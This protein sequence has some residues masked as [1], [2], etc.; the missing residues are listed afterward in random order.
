MIRGFFDPSQ[1]PHLYLNMAV[2]VDGLVPTDAWPLIPF[3]VDTGAS[4][5]VVH[6]KD[7]VRRLGLSVA[8]LT[9]RS[10][11]AKVVGN[12]GVGGAAVS[13]EVPA[14]YAFQSEDGSWRIVEGNLRIAELADNQHLALTSGV[15]PAQTVSNGGTRQSPDDRP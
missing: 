8:Q 5:T 12:I 15:G 10:L 9:N 13:F 14:R 2:Y 3:L 7:A 1:P 11:W 4:Q 6:P